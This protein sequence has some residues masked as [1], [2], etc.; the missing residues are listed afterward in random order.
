MT[1]DLLS[2][3]DQMKQEAQSSMV[4]RRLNPM[5]LAVLKTRRGFQRTGAQKSQ[6]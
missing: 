1:L 4:L 2:L 6:R 3:Q 5:K